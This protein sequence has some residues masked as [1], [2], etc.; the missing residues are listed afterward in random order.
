M[1]LEVNGGADFARVDHPEL[2]ALS[3][4]EALFPRS[5]DRGHLE[6]RLLPE[7]DQFESTRSPDFLAVENELL[8]LRI[9]DR[10]ACQTRAL[11][12]E[13]ERAA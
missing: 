3:T 6:A 11:Q 10:E 13:G 12:G 2:R 9:E 1:A 8:S 7:L 4:F 5:E